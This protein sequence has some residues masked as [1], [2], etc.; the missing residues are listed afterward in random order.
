M[1]SKPP[2]PQ[3]NLHPLCPNSRQLP[4]R[5]TPPARLHRLQ[6]RNLFP[7]LSLHALEPIQQLDRRVLGHIFRL[8]RRGPQRGEPVAEAHAF[9]VSTEMLGDGWDEGGPGAGGRVH[10]V[11]VAGPGGRG[12]GRVV[13]I[14]EE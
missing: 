2:L 14:G 12:R 11:V 7:R 13:D 3:P 4:Q 6:L 5:L 1:Y 10:D 8:T 9:D